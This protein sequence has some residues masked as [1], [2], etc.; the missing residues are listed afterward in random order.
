MLLCVHV[1]RWA[2][3]HNFAAALL[4]SQSCILLSDT[5]TDEHYRKNLCDFVVMSAGQIVTQ[6][7]QYNHTFQK[8]CFITLSQFIS[9]LY[10]QKN[11]RCVGNALIKIGSLSC[12]K[13][14]NVLKSISSYKPF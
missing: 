10:Y 8:D 2:E 13:F 3:T 4:E 9:H 7:I 14:E 5:K 11:L 6:R 12:S 1:R